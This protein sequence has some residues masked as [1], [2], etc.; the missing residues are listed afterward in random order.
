VTTLV[1][2]RTKAELA[3][4]VLRQQIRTGELEPGRR[5]RLNDLTRELGMSPTP[6]REALRLL[7]ADGLVHY[8][9]HQ[10]IVVAEP[11]SE[12]T[13]DV[14][15]LRCLLEPLAVELAVPLLTPEQLRVLEDLHQKLLAAVDARRG[16][17]ISA[18]NASWH[19]AIYDACGSL[20]LRKFIRRLWDVYPW[21]TMWAL[22]GRAEESA[23]EH[24]RIMGA[25][26]VGDAQV[27]AHRLREH[28]LSSHQS[29]LNRLESERSG[30]AR[31][32]EAAIAT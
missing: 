15:R 16:S 29:L 31:E 3:L 5:L 11:S 23:R 9:P 18:S 2:H 8:H 27:A 20:H 24:E 6:I 14:V 26:A 25:V 22:P 32:P 21:R 7:Q 4:Q 28:I 10:G 30:P 17:E 13:E 19:W 12:E 1:H